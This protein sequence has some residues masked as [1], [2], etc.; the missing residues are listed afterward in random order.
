MCFLSHHDTIRLWQRVLARARVP[1]RFTCGFN[2]HMRM[3]LP[4]PRS[5]GMKS[6]K[7]LLLLE[8]TEP[9]ELEHLEQDILR[10]LPRGIELKRVHY[11]EFGEPALPGWARYR[12]TLSECVDRTDLARRIEELMESPKWYIQRAARQRH[13]SRTVDLRAKVMQLELEQKNI[14]CKIRI[15][16]DVTP[17]ID[18]LLFA[19]GISDIKLVP[20]IT[21]LDTGY[22]AYLT[23]PYEIYN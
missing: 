13:P 23:S 17:R 19:I 2:P 22:P 7:E 15:G 10:Q 18:E 4:L 5:V 21:R 12:I 9:S 1:V 3:S 14:M 8:L 6:H 16:I 11:V 20:E